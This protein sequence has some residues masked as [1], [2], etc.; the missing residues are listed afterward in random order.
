MRQEQSLSIPK[1]TDAQRFLERALL[2]H[3]KILNSIPI[4]DFDVEEF[5]VFHGEY[6]DD[7]VAWFLVNHNYELLFK[8]IQLNLLTMGILD[9]NYFKKS[10]IRSHFSRK[11]WAAIGRAIKEWK[12][13]NELLDLVDN[14]DDDEDEDMDSDIGDIGR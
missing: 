7:S 2:A 14:D 4:L 1:N 6:F 9:E 3:A 5:E 11:E 13:E 8:V 12:N 10:P